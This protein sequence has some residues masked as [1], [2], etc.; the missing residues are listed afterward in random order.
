MYMY[1]YVRSTKVQSVCPSLHSDC[2]HANVTCFTVLAWC[3]LLASGYV[4][5]FFCFCLFS[6]VG[7]NKLYGINSTKKTNKSQAPDDNKR[8][9]Q[10]NNLV[11]HTLN[12]LLYP[13]LILWNK[14]V[15]QLHSMLCWID[16]CSLCSKLYYT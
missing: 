4:F 12:P 14:K 5:V 8:N 10:R 3:F 15:Q 6:C 2:F 1:I 13:Q 11:V 9:G 7:M 16:I